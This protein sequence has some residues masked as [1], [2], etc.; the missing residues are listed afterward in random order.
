MH[1]NERRECIRKD[2]KKSLKAIKGSELAEKYEVSRQVIVQDIALLRAVGEQIIS[3]GDGYIYFSYHMNKPKRVFAVR[4]E[5]NQIEMEI[6]TILEYDGT[7]LNVFIH[8][9]I[10]GDLVADMIIEDKIQKRE[11]LK[12]SSEVEFIP[13]MALT[14]NYHFHTVEASSESDL[15]LIE[16]LLKKRGFLA[17]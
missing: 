12:R 13:L 3:T 8:H 11:Y 17:N 5:Q 4:H 9:P 14:D 2:L 1:G 7:I 10:Y 16:A 15:D 6:D